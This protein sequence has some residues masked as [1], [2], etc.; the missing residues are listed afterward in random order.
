MKQAHPNSSI[1]EIDQKL[2]KMIDKFQ[3][4]YEN[5]FHDFGDVL[6]TIKDKVMQ[7]QK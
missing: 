5:Q 7:K 6:S 3:R 4:K 1:Q 2:N